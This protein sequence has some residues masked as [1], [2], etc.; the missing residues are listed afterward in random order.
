MNTSRQAFLYLQASVIGTLANFFSRFLFAELVNFG[1]SIILAN[2][3]GMVFVFLLSYKHAFG[4]QAIQW[5][6]ILKFAIVAHIGLL[7]VWLAATAAHWVVYG[8]VSFTFH[9]DLHTLVSEWGFSG[10]SAAW[11]ARFMDG[12]C[13]GFG[14][15]CGFLVNF[16]GHKYF[17]FAPSES[18]N[19]SA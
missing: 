8:V 2:Y 5:R 9:N 18:G 12:S 17:S 1:W 16:V 7:V 19:F 6:M 4:V 14:I 10:T 11:I 3:V 15:I 13:H